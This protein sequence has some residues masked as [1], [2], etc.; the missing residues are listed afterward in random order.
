MHQQQQHTMWKHTIQTYPLVTLSTLML[1]PRTSPSLMYPGVSMATCSNSST[2]SEK[3]R[4]RTA[5]LRALVW[6]RRTWRPQSPAC[7]ANPF[8][9]EG[10][11]PACR[12]GLDEPSRHGNA[13]AGRGP[14]E[15]KALPLISVVTVLS[16]VVSRVLSGDGQTQDI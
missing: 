10:A 7:C 8:P 3:S 16:K 14:S 13:E 12:R 2:S 5:P 1:L 6:C 9:D 4:P 15:S 11:S